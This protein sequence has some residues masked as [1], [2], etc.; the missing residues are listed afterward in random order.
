[1]SRFLLQFW[2]AI[3][4]LLFCYSFYVH[5]MENKRKNLQELQE[6]TLFLQ[7]ELKIAQ[8]LQEDLLMQ[9]KSQTD[10]SWMEMLMIKQLGM[11]PEGQIKVYFEE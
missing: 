3:L 6:K 7:K 5:G 9:I 2:W 1:M 8:E 4:F 10:P 11:I